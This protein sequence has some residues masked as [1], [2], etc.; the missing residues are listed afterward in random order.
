MNIDTVENNVSL[1]GLSVYR[2]VVNCNI[3]RRFF[4]WLNA[5]PEE[6]FS[7]VKNGTRR[8][9]QYGFEYDYYMRRALPFKGEKS[10]F[11][12]ILSALID[13]TELYFETDETNEESDCYEDSDGALTEEDTNLKRYFNQYIVNVYR[14]GDLYVMEDNARWLYRHEMLQHKGDTMVSVTFRNVSE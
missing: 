12:E 6:N 10:L 9:L 2:G 11:P 8:V 7:K 1:T 14:E 3:K 5:V 13:I 4:E